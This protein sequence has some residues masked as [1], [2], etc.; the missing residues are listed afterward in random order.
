MFGQTD[1]KHIG[2]LI[3][4]PI[5]YHFS[6]LLDQ[7]SSARGWSSASLLS[8]HRLCGVIVERLSHFLPRWLS[9]G[10]QSVISQGKIH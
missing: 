10:W 4:V 3:F 7:P 2:L 5:F 9:T 1:N 6:R 8:V